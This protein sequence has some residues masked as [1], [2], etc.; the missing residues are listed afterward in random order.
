M[1]ALLRHRL[2]DDALRIVW[3]DFGE[4]PA[5]VV[6]LEAFVG[7]PH[8]QPEPVGALT[9]RGDSW[10]TVC[11]GPKR[12][13]ASRA[14][15]DVTQAIGRV[16]RRAT[17]PATAPR[18]SRPTSGT[19]ETRASPG[20]SSPGGGAVTEP[21]DLADLVPAEVRVE[22]A[23]VVAALELHGPAVTR[24]LGRLDRATT[25]AWNAVRPVDPTQDEWRLVERAVGIDRG[26]NA[27]YQLVSTLDPPGQGRAPP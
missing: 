22:L 2:A 18:P 25:A 13:P 12:G 26:W 16:G 7:G 24:A 11:C 17:K 6:A 20:R 27:A 21:R 8:V 10:F 3:Q 4:A 1:T 14:R 23:A 9:T 15:L 19:G 5:Q